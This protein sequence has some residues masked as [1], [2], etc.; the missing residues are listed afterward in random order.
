ML[1]VKRFR[2]NCLQGYELPKRKKLEVKRSL[3]AENHYNTKPYGYNVRYARFSPFQ[4]T[5]VHKCIPDRDFLREAA[6]G[7]VG[8]IKET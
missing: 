4:V 6:V 5:S 2:G 3:F 8:T 7:R 1:G